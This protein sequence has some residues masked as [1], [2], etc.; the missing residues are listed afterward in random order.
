MK[1]EELKTW[2]CYKFVEVDG[3]FIFLTT[4]ETHINKVPKG[5]KAQSAGMIAVY[6]DGLKIVDSYSTSC[7]VGIGDLDAIRMANKLNVPVW[8]EHG[9]KWVPPITKLP[10]WLKKSQKAKKKLRKKEQTVC[11]IC[12][13]RVKEDLVKMNYNG[14]EVYACKK[15]PGVS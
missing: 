2:E 6:E 7:K 8:F 15:H 1:F 4:F 10:K 5:K 13:S 12:G 11:T 14:T 3:E 9:E